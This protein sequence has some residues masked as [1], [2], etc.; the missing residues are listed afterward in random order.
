M[1][2]FVKKLFA[3]FTSN[4]AVCFGLALT[5]IFNVALAFGVIDKQINFTALYCFIF[6]RYVLFKVYEYSQLGAV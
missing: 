5:T 1:L 4:C 6:H 2:V 3:E